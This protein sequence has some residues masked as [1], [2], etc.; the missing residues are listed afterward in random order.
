MPDLKKTLHDLLDSI[1]QTHLLAHADTWSEEQLESLKQEI[2][3]LDL[4]LLCKQQEILRAPKSSRVAAPLLTEAPFCGEH[5][6]D[7][8]IGNERM[9]E[10]KC[11]CVVLA[12]GQAS[13]LR[14]T[15]PKGCIPVS[16][17][18]Q[19]TLFELIA[20]KVK[21]ASHQSGTLLPIAFMTSTA[22]RMATETFFIRHQYFGLNPAQVSF[23][24]QRVW[25]L[26]SLSGDLIL[27]AP[28]KL[29]TGPNGN[30]DFFSEFVGNGIWQKWANQGVDSVRVIPVDNPLALPFD[31][32][33][34]GFHHREANEVSIQSVAKRSAFEKAGSL[35]TL[36]ERVGVAEYGEIPPSTGG[37]INIGLYTFSMPFIH[38]IAAL[39]L[40][41]H[42]AMKAVQTYG[43]IAVPATP[44][45]WKFEEFIFDAFPH[46]L[47]SRALIYPR[48]HCFAPLKNAEGE[49]SLASVQEALLAHEQWLYECITGHPVHTLL[50]LTSDFYYPTPDLIQHW[51]GRPWRIEESL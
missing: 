26:L 17:V 20:N 47:R 30:G 22:N 48:E 33:L 4:G 40:P 3:H 44:N 27:S 32:E 38:R 5:A 41:L 49:D 16:L 15:L 39:D 6:Q 19:K 29:A 36:E 45:A 35:T 11:G 8:D 51:K 2:R 31:A 37:F 7:K 9:R 1:E 25:P 46:A 10:G 28:G 23:F 42:P 13:R 18:H 12:G 50:E 24:S 14:V 43:E 21:S 34:F